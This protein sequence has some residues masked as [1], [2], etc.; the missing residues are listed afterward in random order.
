FAAIVFLVAFAMMAR[1]APQRAPGSV[2]DLQ[3]VQDRIAQYVV[4]PQPPKPVEEPRFKDLSGA[5]EGATAQ[6]EEGNFGKE[7]EKEKEAVPPSASA[8]SGSRVRDR[9]PA[10]TAAWSWA[11]RARRRRAS[12]PA[13]RW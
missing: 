3:A 2:E 6:G 1:L 8:A 5:P 10:V 7:E 9:A 13:R 4:K 12:S 11:A